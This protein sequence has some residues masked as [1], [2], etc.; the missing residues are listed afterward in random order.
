MEL[1]NKITEPFVQTGAPQINT[2]LSVYGHYTGEK[3]VKPISIGGGTN[4]RMF[5]NAVSFGPAM[6]EH[7]YTAH[8][9]H[10][11]ITREQFI[12]NLKMYTA[13]LVELAK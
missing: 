7:E 5:P 3:D 8:T 11:Y 2:L 12:L 1:N 6:P 13:A 9:E 10:E 4:S